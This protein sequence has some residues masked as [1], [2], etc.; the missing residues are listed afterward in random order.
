M[1][2]TT[3]ILS[4]IIQMLLFLYGSG[5]LYAQSVLWKITDNAAHVSY[6]YGTIH[7]TDNRVFEWSDSVYACIEK[8]EVFAGEVDMSPSNLFKAA[9]L[10]ML[11]G[12]ETLED[13]FS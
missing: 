7:I 9:S 1:K 12:E 8:C 13:R 6:L 10:M 2:K 11:P 4:G 3:F 5:N